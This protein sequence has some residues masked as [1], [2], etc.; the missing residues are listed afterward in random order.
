MRVPK[1]LTDKDAQGFWSEIEKKVLRKNTPFC[2][3]LPTKRS[4]SKYKDK[5]NFS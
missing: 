2:K 4:M 1:K 5:R 3:S